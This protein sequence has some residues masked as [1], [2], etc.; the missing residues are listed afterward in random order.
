MS[1][2]IPRPVNRLLDA[3]ARHP[4]ATR[5]VILATFLSVGALAILTSPLATWTIAALF[6]VYVAG[7]GHILQVARL[8]DRLRQTEYDLAAERAEVA[9]LRAG[10]GSAP[11]MQL[12]SI[13]DGGEAL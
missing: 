7:L 13:G 10:D 12:R 2:R 8:R 4:Q 3:A 1:F 5:G 11:T 9:R 6:T